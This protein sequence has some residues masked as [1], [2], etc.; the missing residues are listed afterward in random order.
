M[1]VDD[2]DIGATVSV[3]RRSRGLKRAL[4]IALV[5]AIGFFGLKKLISSSN[6]PNVNPSAWQAVFLTN[7]QVYFGHL[8]DHDRGYTT[9]SN[10]FYLRPTQVLQ[11]GQSPESAGMNL[12]KLGAELHGPQDIMYIPKERILFWEDMKPESQVVQAI[13]AFL[14]QQ[15]P[16]GQ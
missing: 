3:P 9:L 10:I 8:A 14:N 12:V 13:T 5:I 1:V 11:Q 4:V 2:E 15:K 6:F 7:D 16:T